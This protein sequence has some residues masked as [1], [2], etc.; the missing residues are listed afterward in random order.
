ME[1]FFRSLKV[2]LIF[3]RRFDTRASA[4]Q[5]IFDYIEAYYNQKRLHSSLGYLSP[6]EY[7][8]AG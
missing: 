4:R 1:S 7:E 2:E 6:A 3:G 8:V 5:E